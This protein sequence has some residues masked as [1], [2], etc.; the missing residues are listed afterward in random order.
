MEKQVLILTTTHDFVRKFELENIKI[1]QQMGCTVHY[2][3]N[4]KEPAYISDRAL[5]EQK[6]VRLHHIDIARSPFLWRE[7]RQALQQL[8]KLIRDCRIQMIHCHT[9]VGGLLG[10]LAGHFFREW[11]V[12]VIYTAHGFHFYKGAPLFNKII[13]Y[14]VEKYL[15][16]Y[17]NVLITINEE[18]YRNAG[19]FRLKKGGRVYKIP[20]AGLNRRVFAPLSPQ[21]QKRCRKKLGIGKDA[22]F[23]VSVGE[24]NGNKNHEIVLD[25]LKL[26]KD[27]NRISGIRYGVCGDGFFREWLGEKIWELG[28]EDTVELYGY[29]ANIPEILGCAAA[30]V[31]PSKREGL[32]MA[33][34]ESLAMGVPVIASDNRGTR[35]YMEHGK[36]GYVC[37]A[38]DAEGFAEGI[39]RIRQLEQK[40]REEMRRNCILSVKP[41]DRKYTGAVMKRIYEEAEKEYEQL[42]EGQHC[43]GSLQ[44]QRQKE[45]LHG[46]TVTDFSEL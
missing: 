31:F 2:A 29:C 11:P 15:A 3:A 10:R 42:S 26:L 22:F 6:G 8:L 37:G 33:G 21:E 46:V 24:L 34:L 18:D 27:R 25:A 14:Q 12:Y 41:F 28:L 5:L 45:I 16:G 38:S 7:N 19:K 17:T 35:E 23:L 30:S 43:N 4:M 44:S 32:G 40:K 1:L 9:P 36:N 20:G 13:Y 39:E